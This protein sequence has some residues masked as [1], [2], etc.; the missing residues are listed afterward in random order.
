MMNQDVFKPKT[1]QFSPQSPADVLHRPRM[2]AGELFSG[3]HVSG[4]LDQ[5]PENLPLS[6][7]QRNQ[8]PTGKGGPGLLR[9]HQD[10]GAVTFRFITH[11]KNGAQRER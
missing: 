5:L 7:G 8:G 3:L 10:N 11:A 9:N 1:S 4:N 6:P 2:A